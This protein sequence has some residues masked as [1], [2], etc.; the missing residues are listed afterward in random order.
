VPSNSPAGPAVEPWSTVSAPLP[1]P[2]DLPVSGEIAVWLLQIP[3]APGVAAADGWV[4]DQQEIQR[5][6]RLRNDIARERYITSHVGLRVLLGRYLG[7]EPGEVEL[8]REPCPM[9][10]CGKPHGRPAVAGREGLHFSLSHSGDAALF[11]FAG[12]PVGADIEIRQGRRGGDSLAGLLGHLHPDERAVIEEL[13]SSLREEAFLSCW[14][15]KEAYLKGIGTGL[16]GGLSTH[17][18]GLAEG[19]APARAEAG[20]GAAPRG[21]SA[22]PAGTPDGWAFVDLDAP[23]G[24]HAAVALRTGSPSA[25]RPVATLRH[26]R[27]G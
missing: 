12:V 3:Y 6:A 2:A 25:D 24:Y 22:R 26:L 4:L 11:A 8:T 15:R 20:V 13:P 18:V 14:V 17:H 1:S 21:G 16:P 23:A 5:A 9:P 19:L 7:I 27:L 10:G